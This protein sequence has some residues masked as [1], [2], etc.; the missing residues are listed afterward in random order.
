MISS[1]LLCCG[2]PDNLSRP[3]VIVKARLRQ[4][5]GAGLDLRRARGRTPLVVDLVVAMTN[6]ISSMTQRWLLISTVCLVSSSLGCCNDIQVTP[7]G[8]GGRDGG[9]AGDAGTMP[10]AGTCRV[11]DGGFVGAGTWLSILY[12]SCV[13][14]DPGLNPDGWTV[15]DAGQACDGFLPL[16]LMDDPSTIPFTGVCIVRDSYPLPICYGLTPGATGCNGAI[17]ACV[18]GFC[19]DA[20]WCEVN[21]NLGILNACGPGTS[22][23][24]GSPQ[25]NPCAQGPCCLDAGFDGAVGGAG[26]CCGLVDGGVHTCLPSGAVC[27]DRSDC[28]GGLTCAGQDAVTEGNDSEAL[29]GLCE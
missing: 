3:T 16:R 7:V 24:A 8:D 25:A 19:N 27:Y 10:D 5:F 15:L 23:A 18:G 14:C 21:Q 17:P 13:I 22:G 6:M 2:A 28:C 20:G 1:L 11:G 26:W 12:M 9:N 4:T 29:Y